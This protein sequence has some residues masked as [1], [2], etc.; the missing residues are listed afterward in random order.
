MSSV[1]LHLEVRE[2]RGHFFAHSSIECKSFLK[3]SIWSIYGILTGTSTL[4]QSGPGNNDNEVSLELDPHHHM[5]VW[6]LPK[7][8]LFFWGKE[9][10]THSAGDYSQCILS[11]NNRSIFER[12]GYLCKILTFNTVEI[13]QRVL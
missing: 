8:P 7:N 2:S 10:L 3:T 9:G 1:N 6:V 12:E 5:Q 11:S 13:W 4:D